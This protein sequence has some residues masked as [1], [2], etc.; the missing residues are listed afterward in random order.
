MTRAKGSLVWWAAG[1]LALPV[2]IGFALSGGSALGQETD[3]TPTAAA[4]GHCQCY[5]NRFGDR[6]GHF[7]GY[8]YGYAGQGQLVAGPAADPHGLSYEHTDP[9]R[10][11]H[12]HNN[13]IRAYGRSRLP[14]FEL[15]V[16]V[17]PS[18]AG[19]GEAASHRKRWPAG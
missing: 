4:I 18:G 19:T 16:V 12:T 15:A 1:L 9:D 13:S 14:E 11:R 2:M 7:N 17:R 5:G 3:T 8:G 10:D 6:D